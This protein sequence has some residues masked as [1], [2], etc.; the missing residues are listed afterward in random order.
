MRL[1]GD[2]QKK[3]FQA[4]NLNKLA[5]TSEHKFYSAVKTVLILLWKLIEQGKPKVARQLLS[6]SLVNSYDESEAVT[7]SLHLVAIS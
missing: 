3:E 7:F 6:V 4:W 2:F 1:M 5:L